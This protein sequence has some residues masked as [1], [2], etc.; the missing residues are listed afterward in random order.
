M[1]SADLPD[2]PLGFGMALAQN[3]DAMAH[4]AALSVQQK[5]WV[6]AH[7]AQ[8]HSRQEMRQITE[9]IAKGRYPEA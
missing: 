3:A 9:Q 7:T 5:R 6:I 2:M 8:I 1:Q 4:F